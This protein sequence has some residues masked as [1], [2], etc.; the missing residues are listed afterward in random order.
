MGGSLFGRVVCPGDAKQDRA[1]EK[2]CRN[3]SASPGIITEL[4]QI[5]G[6]FERDRGRFQQQSEIDHEKKLW[7]SHR[8][9]A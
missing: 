7:F 3:D 8:K 2:I 1:D 9:N 5:K 6:T 4:V